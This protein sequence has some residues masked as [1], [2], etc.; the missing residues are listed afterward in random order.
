MAAES[1]GTVWNDAQQLAER[2]QLSG[3]LVMLRRML[4]MPREWSRRRRLL[5]LPLALAGTPPAARIRMARALA[6]HRLR[7][8]LVSLSGPDGSG[9]S[10]H[11]ARLQ[12]TLES[13]GVP[14]ARAWAPTTTRPPLPAVVRGY[15]DR[16]LRARS[17]PRMAAEART[18]QVGA[19]YPHLRLAEH[20]WARR[21]PPSPSWAPRPR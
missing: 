18:T 10:T 4:G 17:G 5:E 20:V 19:G 8:V 3:G 21:S 7:P 9:K 12:Q 16:R 14:A 1:G 2:M 15:L 6:P 13:L 11:A